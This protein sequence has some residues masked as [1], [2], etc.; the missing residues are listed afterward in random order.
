MHDVR[1][2]PEQLVT[3]GG[4]STP[5]SPRARRSST[6]YWHYSP[7]VGSLAN[8]QHSCQIIATSPLHAWLV[9]LQMTRSWSTL[10][11]LGW[12]SWRR[13]QDYD[14]CIRTDKHSQSI[15][16]PSATECLRYLEVHVRTLTL[17]LPQSDLKVSV[18]R[19]PKGQLKVT[20]RS[21]TYSDL[22]ITLNEGLR[23]DMAEVVS[24]FL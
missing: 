14:T 19:W 5:C 1:P 22:K 10:I 3:F 12:W 8:S 23:P 24:T 17:R 16:G 11:V 21:C 7:P 15:Y 4:Y 13:F 6:R 2:R 20:W 9:V 18:L